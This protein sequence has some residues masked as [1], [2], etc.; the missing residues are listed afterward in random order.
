MF[1]NDVVMDM[2]DQKERKDVTHELLD[3]LADY[4]EKLFTV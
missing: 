3:V 4:V 2:H 1:L